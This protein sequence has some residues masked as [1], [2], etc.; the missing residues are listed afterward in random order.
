MRCLQAQ[1]LSDATP[2]TGKLHLL[3]QIAVTF[4]PTM[5]FRLSY[6]WEVLSLCDIFNNMTLFYDSNRFGRGGFVKYGE[7]K[8]DS[9]TKL[10][11]K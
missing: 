11:N 10:I 2:L 5:Q 3:Q 1:T 8:G 4:E 6:D 9:V 7:E